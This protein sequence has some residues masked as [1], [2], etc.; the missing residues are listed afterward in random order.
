[1]LAAARHIARAN[2]RH[3]ARAFSASSSVAA[4][5][6]GSPG[7]FEQALQ[8]GPVIC[9][10]GYLFELERRGYVQIGAFVP[11][12]VL[13]DPE[14]VKQLHREFMR[15]GSDILEAFTYYGHRDKLRLIGK[16]HLLEELNRQAVQLAQEVAREKDGA[17]ALVAGNICNTTTYVPNDADS[18]RETRA[19]FEEQVGWAKEEG[20]DLIIGETFEYLSEAQ[21]ALDVIQAAGLPSVIT[22]AILR[23]GETREGVAPADAMVALKEAG[24]T[25]VGLN[26]SRGPDTMLPLLQDITA[27]VGDH[28]VAALPVAYRTC[29]EHPTFQSLTQDADM[30]YC[31]LDPHTCT[32]FDFADFTQKAVAMGV[33]YLGVCCGGAPHHVR[34]MSQALGREPPSAEFAPDLSKHFAFGTKE[35]L[36][37]NTDRSLEWREKM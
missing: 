23:E 28:P 32:R 25:V 5:A 12:V 7:R 35:G 20:V 11:E 14:A 1:M 21:I 30:K 15:A 22:Q 34:A 37:D 16:E 13:N 33:R 27:A 8:D 2:L 17:P 31:D 29:E 26:C 3:H 36:G 24:A 19:Q 9:A 4:E 6:I 10:E 18:E